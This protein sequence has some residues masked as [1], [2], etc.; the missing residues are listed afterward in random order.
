MTLQLA[1]EW[2]ILPE[3]IARMRGGLKWAARWS[4]YQEAIKKNDEMQR[5][6]AEKKA[7]R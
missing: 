6:I 2:G 4:A 3:E 1:K 7:R 5:K